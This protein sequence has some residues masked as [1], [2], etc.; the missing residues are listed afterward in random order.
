[1]SA[2]HQK[3]Y[4]AKQRIDYFAENKNHENLIIPL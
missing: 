4:T 3:K 1:M 2:H